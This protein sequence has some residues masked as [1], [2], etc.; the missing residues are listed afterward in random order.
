MVCKVQCAMCGEKK[1]PNKKPT[2]SYLHVF[3]HIYI[4]GIGL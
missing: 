2:L 3:T 1:N 4:L